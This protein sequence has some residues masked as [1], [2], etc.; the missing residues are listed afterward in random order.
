[1]SFLKI[2]DQN[3]RDETVKEFLELKNRIKDNFR[4]ERIRKIETQSDLSKFFIPVTTQTQELTKKVRELPRRIA[5][6]MP[7]QQTSL[8]N[9]LPPPY[10]APFADEYEVPGEEKEKFLGTENFPKEISWDGY[11]YRIGEIPISFDPKEGSV[12]VEGEKFTNSS[13][14]YDLLTDKKSKSGME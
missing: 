14:I 5:K 12:F 1:M 3:K 8:P 13:K 2:K 10:E 7:K 9:E 4:R 11:G 6:A